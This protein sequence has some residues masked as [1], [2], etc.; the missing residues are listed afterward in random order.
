MSE[1]FRTEQPCCYKGGNKFKIKKMNDRNEIEDSFPDLILLIEA[2]RVIYKWYEPD[3]KIG[4]GFLTIYETKENSLLGFTGLLMSLLA[5][6]D[7][8]TTSP[9][10]LVNHIED[11]FL[12]CEKETI[13]FPRSRPLPG[14]EIVN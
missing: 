3:N 13:E 1:S 9:F 7:T 2:G 11:I 12:S 8:V 4:K 14:I 5:E 10:Q 6:R